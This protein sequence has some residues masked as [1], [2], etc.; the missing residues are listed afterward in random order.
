MDIDEKEEE[1]EVT[2]CQEDIGKRSS[3]SVAA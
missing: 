1:K 3:N 2:E